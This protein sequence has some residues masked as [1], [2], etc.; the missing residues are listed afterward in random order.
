LIDN[1]VT[2]TKLNHQEQ[3]TEPINKGE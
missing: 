1:A 2:T 3:L